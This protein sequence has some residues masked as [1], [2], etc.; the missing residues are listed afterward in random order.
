MDSPLVLANHMFLTTSCKHIHEQSWCRDHGPHWVPLPQT[1][2]RSTWQP[3]QPGKSRDIAAKQRSPW[4]EIRHRPVQQASATAVT[5]RLSQYFHALLQFSRL[6][7]RKSSTVNII[8]ASAQSIPT[9]PNALHVR[10][11]ML[12]AFFGGKIFPHMWINFVF[13]IFGRCV[14]VNQR[15]WKY[16]IMANQINLGAGIRI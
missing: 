12:E 3:L 16:R 9:W 13:Q 7:L 8:F 6:Y 1:R 4:L 15:L 14:C 5:T 11:W 10:G 2:K